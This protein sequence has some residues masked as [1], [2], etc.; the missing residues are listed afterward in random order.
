[1]SAKSWIVLLGN[2]DNP[3][4][5]KM[6]CFAPVVL[7]PVAQHMVA[8]AVHNQTVLKQGNCKNA[9]CHTV[10]P[11]NE[12]TIVCPPVNC[13]LSKPNTFWKLNKTLYSLR[14]NP[15]HWFKT[16]SKYFQDIWLHPT[17]QGSC[18]FV[19][20]PLP[21]KALIY[22][23]LFVNDFVYFSLIQMSKNILKMLLHQK[24]ELNLWVKLTIFLVFSSIGNATMMAV[25]VSTFCK[26]LMQIKSL[27]WWAFQTLFP[28]R[29]WHH[30]SLASWLTQFHQ[31][32]C[33]S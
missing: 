24:S 29:Q 17:S 25:S 23:A 14:W 7:A 22:V 5:L 3:P 30:T 13:P 21:G 1:M 10:L 18:L 4:W 33:L 32:T 19:G 8:L 6:D 9:F 20:T 27:M 11:E 15:Q 2:H 31:L 26:K 12:V 16:L 28:L